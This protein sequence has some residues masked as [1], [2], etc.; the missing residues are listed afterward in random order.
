MNKIVRE[1]VDNEI[2]NIASSHERI[3]TVQEE[4]KNTSLRQYLHGKKLGDYMIVYFRRYIYDILQ[5]NNIS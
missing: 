2:D 1:S 4:K 3:R 5:Q